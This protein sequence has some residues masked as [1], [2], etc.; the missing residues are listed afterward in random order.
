MELHIDV[1]EASNRRRVK[2]SLPAVP[3]VQP[4]R[5][6]HLATPGLGAGVI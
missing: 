4:T 3:V 2:M 6:P 5:L 1:A